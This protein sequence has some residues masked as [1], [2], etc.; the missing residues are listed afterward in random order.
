[1][2]SPVLHATE[3]HALLHHSLLVVNGHTQLYH[4]LLVI[5]NHIQS[6]LTSGHQSQVIISQFSSGNQW[7]NYTTAYQWKATTHK[8]SLTS[9]EWGVAQSVHL[10]KFISSYR[11]CSVD[12]FVVWAIFHSNQWSPTGPVNAG[13]VYPVCG[14]VNKTNPLLL[15]WRRSL[16]DDSRFPYTWRPKANDMKI[17]VF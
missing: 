1:M 6:D 14:K 11:S 9:G 16:C 2:T 17:N 12:P 4:S 5:T 13:M 7:H 15:I 10:C 3:N 8:Y